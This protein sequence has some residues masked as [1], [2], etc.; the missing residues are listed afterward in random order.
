MKERR[1]GKSPVLQINSRHD[2]R[3]ILGKSLILKWTGIYTSTL[4]TPDEDAR[5]RC[6][7]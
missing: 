1:E 7:L 5:P 6:S 2:T 3:K 4:L